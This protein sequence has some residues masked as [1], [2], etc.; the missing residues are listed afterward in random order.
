MSR[1]VV[2]SGPSGC[3]K[4]TILQRV[5]REYPD[6]YA[7][8]ISHTTRKPRAGERHGVEYYFT[9]KAEMTEAIERGEFLEHA[10]FGG[11]L[12]GTS[13]ESVRSIQRAGKRC[14]LDIE[15]QGVRAVR[16]SKL[17]PICVLLKPPSMAVLESRLRDRGTETEE[18]IQKRLNLAL[19]DLKAAEAESELFDYVII[20]DDIDQAY[21]EL[22]SLL[23]SKE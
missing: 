15:I 22:C 5:L 4:S 6:Q 19:K 3:G 10:E 17:N 16:K 13:L 9:T 8:C 11:N 12:Y 18:A 2:L 21:R 14:I 1:P 20:N 23:S 7:V